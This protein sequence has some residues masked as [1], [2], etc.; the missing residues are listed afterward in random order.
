MADA[1]IAAAEAEPGDDE[2]LFGKD[3][4]V[5]VKSAS[6][7][8]YTGTIASTDRGTQTYRVEFTL[9][10]S[11]ITDDDIANNK[12][13]DAARVRI[14]MWAPA[15]EKP[16]GEPGNRRKWSYGKIGDA[17]AKADF[18]LK[19]LVNRQP[20]PAH[21]PKVQLM[22]DSMKE[23]HGARDGGDDTG[24]TDVTS[25]ASKGICISASRAGW[26]AGDPKEYVF[27][28][29]TAEA[30]AVMLM[31]CRVGGG[32]WGS[33]TLSDVK[34]AC[35]CCGTTGGDDVEKQ[36]KFIATKANNYR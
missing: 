19:R 31:S 8:T 2:L 36:K 13:Q 28:E 10:P 18:V 6:G 3:D 33:N 23:D 25:W 29:L 35:N 26:K 7:K 12:D 4:A 5:E 14:L 27:E 21:P 17:A 9:T 15:M 32:L 20:Q 30:A 22:I 11:D 24:Y 1:V 16:M 34:C